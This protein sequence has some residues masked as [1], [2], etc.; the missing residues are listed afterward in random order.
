MKNPNVELLL[1]KH[2]RFFKEPESSCEE[3]VNGP[4]VQGGLKVGSNR[5]L[6]S[7]APEL[8]PQH[9]SV[10]DGDMQCRPTHW[11]LDGLHPATRTSNNHQVPPRGNMG[12]FVFTQR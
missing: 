5:L 2:Y 9:H 6:L 3:L 7:S 8:V 1:N 10:T 12:C 4:G 11:C